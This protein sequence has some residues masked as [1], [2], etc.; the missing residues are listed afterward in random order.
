MTVSN[1]D[2]TLTV[3]ASEQYTEE[4]NVGDGFPNTYYA[5]TKDS[6]LNVDQKVIFRVTIFLKSAPT[7]PISSE[8]RL[9]S[10]GV[11]ASWKTK[12][13]GYASVSSI[14]TIN[15]KYFDFTVT[16][17]KNGNLVPTIT[18]QIRINGVWQNVARRSTP[19]VPTITFTK[20]AKAPVD[21][22]TTVTAPDYK[23]SF[24]DV[25]P[26]SQAGPYEWNNCEQYWVRYWREGVKFVQG[27][28]DSLKNPSYYEYN[29]QVKFY[30]R[31]GDPKN[32][33]VRNF[34]KEQTRNG[35]FYKKNSPSQQALA[36]LNQAKNC[37]KPVPPAGAGNPPPKPTPERVV[38]A[39]NFNP[40]PHI[41]TRHFAGRIWDD[42]PADEEINVYDQLATFYVDPEIV[43]LPDVKQNA[44]LG[45]KSAILN[46]FWG[47]RFLFNPQYISYNLSSN[48]TVDWTRPNENNAALVA[49]GIGGSFT[50]NILLDRVADMAT[51]KQWQKTGQIDQGIYPVDM[52]REQCAGILHRGTEYD[53]EYLYRVINGNPQ[54]V[55]LMGNDP[56]DGL[57]LFSANMG[58]LTQ[59]PFIFKVSDKM[60]FKVIM[61]NISVEHSMFTREM[62]PIRTVVQIQLERLPDLESG[63]FSKFDKAERLNKINPLIAASTATTPLS[64]AELVARRRANL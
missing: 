61:Q 8:I 14:R 47:F 42:A 38:K 32:P 12:V 63:D 58:Y 2:Y 7:V 37:A 41:S 53:L 18:P 35:G 19:K 52:D 44:L 5:I 26:G 46:R 64:T 55:I 36:I 54:K 33:T 25:L 43:D 1:Y 16:A 62:V 24:G 50:V 40:Y 23:N 22:P 31:G 9:P 59:L 28:P 4:P 45:G 20:A 29:V 60:R 34:G 48:T 21:V 6:V 15:N 57:E 10:D 27:G 11:F 3:F 17:T 30:N 13:A 56:K 51:M 39:N 49:S